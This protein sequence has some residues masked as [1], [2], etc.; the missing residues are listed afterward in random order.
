[1]KNEELINGLRW[2]AD[3]S[4][5]GEKCPYFDEKKDFCSVEEILNDAADALEAAEHRIA[6]LETALAACRVQRGEKYE[7]P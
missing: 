5:C 3:E 7:N 1:M 4:I 2:C 6:D